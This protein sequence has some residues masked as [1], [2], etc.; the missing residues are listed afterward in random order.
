MDF[1]RHFSDVSLSQAWRETIFS[2]F[3]GIVLIARIYLDLSDRRRNIDL[4][5]L[6]DVT[7]RS[8]WHG[9]SR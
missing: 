8:P 1:P 4:P 2:T 3:H 6:Y 7:A 9:G 5:F